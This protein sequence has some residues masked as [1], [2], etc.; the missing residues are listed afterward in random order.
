[1]NGLVKK[2]VAFLEGYKME[3]L[4][5]LDTPLMN[6]INSDKTEN[7]NKLHSWALDTIE[8]IDKCLAVLSDDYKLEDKIFGRY[9]SLCEFMGDAQEEGL[10]LFPQTMF[11]ILISVV[12]R[13]I[14]GDFFEKPM[15]NIY[16]LMNYKFV[17]I[18]SKKIHGNKDDVI[19]ILRGETTK[20]K[21]WWFQINE[22]RNV[23]LR[24]ANEEDTFV[25]N[26]KDIKEHFLD[27]QSTY[28]LEDIEIICRA[29]KKLGVDEYILKK[30]KDYLKQRLA[31]RPVKVEKPVDPNGRAARKNNPVK[32]TIAPKKS[33]EL[34]A[35]EW[36]RSKI[37]LETIEPI[38]CMSL[39]EIVEVVIWLK[40]DNYPISQ[41]KA[42]FL[43]KYFEN[44]FGREKMEP[45]S[46]FE[47]IKPKL[48][49]LINKGSLDGIVIH[50]LEKQLLDIEVCK[51]ASLKENLE[52]ELI[53]RICSYV[54]DDFVYEILEA[55]KKMSSKNSFAKKK[56]N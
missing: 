17:T 54:S 15:L 10:E 29:F 41:I 11:D 33:P 52:K 18:S 51:V 44:F 24:L 3:L 2:F 4:H 35:E 25:L 55:E 42:N 39:D 13:N 49:Y 37:N 45:Q 38:N 56:I 8:N 20:K 21:W 30:I 36:I 27:K 23:A 7:I 6:E 43:K 1:M 50:D 46:F 32:R 48:D 16:S 26:H 19:R 31:N 28:T 22:I 14:R 9:D 53:K 5:L 12:Q 40:N 47:N 34:V